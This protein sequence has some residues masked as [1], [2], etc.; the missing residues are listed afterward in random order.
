VIWLPTC[1]RLYRGA[2]VARD[3][4]LEWTVTQPAGTAL[5]EPPRFT[6]EGTV[7]DGARF[8]VADSQHLT[9]SAPERA[10]V[11]VTVRSGS[12]NATVSVSPG[13]FI[14]L[15]VPGAPVTPTADLARGRTTFPTSPLPAG[16]TAPG[17]AVDGDPRTAWRPGPS[18]RMVVDLGAVCELSAVRLT[19]TGGWVCPAR[20]ES[21]TD[22]LT[23]TSVN[24]LPEP[25]RVATTA[26]NLTARYLAVT[27]VG[28]RPGNAELAE[29]AVFGVSMLFSGP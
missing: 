23:Y 27:A 7:P 19:W 11:A 4:G 5:V 1:T 2:Q 20:F 12:W 25:A 8:T 16:M 26:V 29:L 24:L 3:G 22:G 17:L 10:G 21:S 13:E 15:A 18:G 9:V 28:W 14:R 6:V